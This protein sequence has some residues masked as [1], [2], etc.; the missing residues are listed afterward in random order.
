MKHGID[1]IENLSMLKS[2]VYLFG[3]VKKSFCCSII[4]IVF[5]LMIVSLVFMFP[6][7][8][9]FNINGNQ[10]NQ[11][12]DTSNCIVND[13]NSLLS[14][15]LTFG[16]YYVLPLSIIFLCYLRVFLHVRRTG[17]R[18]VKRLVSSCSITLR[19]I[20]WLELKELLVHHVHFFKNLFKLMIKSIWISILVRCTTSINS[21][22]KTTSS[23][24]TIGTYISICIVLVTNTYIRIA[25]LF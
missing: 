23:T 19:K 20:L 21:I 22:K 4:L 15:I 25:K 14:C 2:F 7:A 16:F 9:F 17:H 10:H 3:L 5:F 18:V 11:S 6:Y 13:N 8:Y 24:C 12:S 1:H